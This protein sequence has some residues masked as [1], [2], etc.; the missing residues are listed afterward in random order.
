MLSLATLSALALA[1][2]PARFSLAAF[3]ARFS[4]AGA[5]FCLAGAG[6][7]ARVCLAGEQIGKIL[8]V[9]EGA[10]FVRRTRSTRTLRIHVADATVDE[11]QCDQDD[12]DSEGTVR[13]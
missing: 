12:V 10:A 1:A 13:V 2:F 11:H 4:L 3:P 5:G 6:F 8:A 9:V 7:L